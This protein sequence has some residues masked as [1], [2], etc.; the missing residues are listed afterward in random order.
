MVLALALIGVALLGASVWAWHKN[1]RLTISTMPA[2][3][4]AAWCWR[5]LIGLVLGVGS[6][7]LRYPLEGGG[8]NYIVYGVPF[9]AY[10]FDQH[11]HD[12]VGPLTMPALIFNCVTWA[13]LPQLFLWVF[14]GRNAGRP[15]TP[16]GA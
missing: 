7:F 1:R 9:M 5:W 15:S 3:W 6:F 2:L 13:M 4:R 10:A 8:N 16:P 12:Y 14:G 11:G